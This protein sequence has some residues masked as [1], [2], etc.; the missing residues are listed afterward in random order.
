MSETSDLSERIEAEFAAADKRLRELRDQKVREYE[1]LLVRHQQAEVE[2]KRLAADVVHPRMKQ[3][4]N[5]FQNAEVVETNNGDGCQCVVSFS[6]TPQFPAST[7]LTMGV[8]YDDE[9]R[10]LLVFY[11]LEILPIFMQYDHADQLVVP[12]HLPD[13]DRVAQWVEQ[14][15]VAFTRTYL[16]LEFVDEYQRDNLVTDPVANLRISR[17]I[18]QSTAE[19]GG[20]TWYFLT[21]ENRQKFV[22]DPHRY[23]GPARTLGAGGKLDD[24]RYC[25]VAVT[26]S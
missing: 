4:L 24:W 3:L 5:H 26:S 13:D 16:Q 14:K 22:A 25:V 17:L 2:A 7:T 21:E 12:L 1:E 19:Y 20:H 8:T 18:A 10:N 6:H 11:S 23:A 9:V 15:L